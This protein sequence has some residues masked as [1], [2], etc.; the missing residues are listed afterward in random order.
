MAVSGMIPGRV[1]APASGLGSDSP[2]A[3]KDRAKFEQERQ[4][5]RGTGKDRPAVYKPP[6]IKAPPSDAIHGQILDHI[7]NMTPAQ[8]DAVRTRLGI[9]TTTSKKIPAPTKGKLPVGTGSSMVKGLA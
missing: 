6:V 3:G 4:Q 9:P 2:G 7:D 1:K 5:D 8:R